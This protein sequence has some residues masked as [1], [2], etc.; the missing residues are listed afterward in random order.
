MSAPVSLTNPASTS[1]KRVVAFHDLPSP[2]ELVSSNPLNPHQSEKVE[3]DRQEIADV[4]AGDDDRLVVVV[5]PCSVHDPDAAIDYANRLAPLAKRLDQDLKIV[6]RVYFE[7]PRTTV[8]WKGLI[9]DPHLNETYDVAEGLRLARKVLIDVVNLDLPVGCEF[10]E[11][12]SPQYYADAV[13]WGAIGARTTESQVHRQ[14][15]SGMSMPIGF[16]NGTDGNVQVAID[17]VQSAQSPHFFFGTSDHGTPSV[18]ETAGNSNSHIILRGGTDGPNH[19]AESVARAAGKLGEGARLMI[20]ASHANSGKDH[21]RQVGV[22]REIADQIAAG[23]D[24]IAGIMIE[25]F[26]VGGAQNLDPAKLKING[27]EGLVYGQS[28][29]DK[30]VDIDTTVDLLAELAAAVRARRDA[31]TA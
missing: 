30:C 16:K 3:R 8:G 12:N 4:F 28:V 14:L 25:S 6:M 19:D 17:A 15:A 20:D 29:T 24:A 22:V 21:V 10:L 11:P 9:N 2:V 27:G 7:K 5:G 1:N 26:L 18:V 23:N 13:A 31:A